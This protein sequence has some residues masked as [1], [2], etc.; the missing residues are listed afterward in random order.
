MSR[1]RVEQ[2]LPALPGLTDDVEDG[3]GEPRGVGPVERVGG[4]FEIGELAVRAESGAHE[5][6]GRGDGDRCR[7]ASRGHE[8]G[9]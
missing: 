8:R 9:A 3:V 5:A 4:E 1:R 6:V 7:V 2:R